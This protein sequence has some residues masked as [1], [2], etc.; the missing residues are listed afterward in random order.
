MTDEDT[1]YVADWTFALP[2]V[3]FFLCTIGLFI[4]GHVLTQTLSLSRRQVPSL[5]QRPL[6][7]IRYLSYRGFHIKALGWNSAPVGL[8]LLAAVGATYFFCEF[9]TSP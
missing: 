5:L 4:I 9:N 3:A 7:A 6:A 2:T 8:L 1:R